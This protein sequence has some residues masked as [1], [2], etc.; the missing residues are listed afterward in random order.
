MSTTHAGSVADDDALIFRRQLQAK[1]G[2][3]SETM[4]RYI[5]DGR[6]PPPDVRMSAKTAGWKTATLRAK[7][8]NL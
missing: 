7:G 3:C 1:L 4:R 2:V 5:R 6:L 8:I